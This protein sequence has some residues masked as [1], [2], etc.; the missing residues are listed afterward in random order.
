M[1]A[2]IHKNLHRKEIASS[3]SKSSFYRW[4]NGNT[5]HLKNLSACDAFLGTKITLEYARK[6]SAVALQLSQTYEAAKVGMILD[7]SYLC[8]CDKTLLGDYHK[9]RIWRTLNADDGVHDEY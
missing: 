8:E 2:T 5:P 1:F 9:D 7:K 4:L 6:F 3:V